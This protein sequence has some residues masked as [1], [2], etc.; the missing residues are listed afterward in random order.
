MSKFTYG[1][2]QKDALGDNYY[3]VYLDGKIMG[4]VISL[5]MDTRSELEGCVE[6][7]YYNRNVQDLNDSKVFKSSM[8]ALTYLSVNGIPYP[9]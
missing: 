4:S 1:P 5:R 7:R 9:L 8:E 6:L 2:I 3:N